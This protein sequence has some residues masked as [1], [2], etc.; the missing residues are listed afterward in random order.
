M[1]L[2]FLINRYGTLQQKVLDFQKQ[3][4]GIRNLIESNHY[5]D[6]NQLL[7]EGIERYQRREKSCVSEM[8]YLRE[9]IEQRV[10]DDFRKFMQNSYSNKL[11]GQP[12]LFV[13]C[14][15]GNALQVNLEI[16]KIS[17][18]GTKMDLSN[19]LDRLIDFEDNY[20]FDVR[21]IVPKII[22]D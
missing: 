4:R 13:N 11:S 17:F 10:E 15:Y 5:R 16:D 9:T 12:R 20:S 6:I 3:E 19:Y 18:N 14:C 7:H 22:L 2:A 21:V 1:E 8:G